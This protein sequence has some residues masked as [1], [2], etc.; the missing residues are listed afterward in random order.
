MRRVAFSLT[1][2][3]A[4]AAAPA[5][6]LVIDANDLDALAGTGDANGLIVTTQIPNVTISGIL[7]PA[8]PFIGGGLVAPGERDDPMIVFNTNSNGLGGPADIPNFTDDPDLQAPF[9]APLNPGGTLGMSDGPARPGNIFLAHET[10]SECGAIQASR[11]WP[12]DDPAIGYSIIFEF[13]IP[14]T[15]LEFDIFDLDAGQQGET[16]T[17]S[18]LDGS[19]VQTIGGASIGDSNS[20]TIDATAFFAPASTSN[21]TA[22]IAQFS[23]SGG[24]NRIVYEEVP[25]PATPLLLLAGALLGLRLRRRA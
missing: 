7:G 14:V 17:I 19:R 10:P 23:S 22:F 12:A 1:A 8:S 25:S 21:V 3:I 11:C 15:I 5:H 6:A 2:C 16:V 9:G 24:I 13:A 20:A 18:L 4:L